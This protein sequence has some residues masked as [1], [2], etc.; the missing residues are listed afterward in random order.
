MLLTIQR[1]DKLTFAW[2]NLVNRGIIPPQF[3]SAAVT[4][5]AQNRVEEHSGDAVYGEILGEFILAAHHGKLKII[6]VLFRRYIY[7]FTCSTFIP[8]RAQHIGKIH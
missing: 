8:L 5:Q 4:R 3:M 7:S 2:V 6:A 1:L